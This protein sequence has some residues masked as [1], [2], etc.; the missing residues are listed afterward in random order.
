M[1]QIITLFFVLSLFTTYSV[2]RAIASTLDKAANFTLK[3]IDGKTVKLSDFKGKII[4]LNFWATWC[5]PCKRELPDLISLYTTYKKKGVVFLGIALDEQ[6]VSI[7]KPFV[8][9]YKINYPILLGGYEVAQAYGGV[10]AIP[11]T[12]F[13]DV[14]GMIKKMLVGMQTKKAFEDELKALM[15]K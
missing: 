3:D 14:R 10:S 8:Q 2:D 13:I 1:K 4:L 9:K 12:F 7:V 5:G 11:T 15:K 6:G